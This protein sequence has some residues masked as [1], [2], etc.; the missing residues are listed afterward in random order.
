MIQLEPFC[1]CSN[2]VPGHSLTHALDLAQICGFHHIELASI[3]GISE[4]IQIDRISPGYAAQILSALE[5]RGLTCHAVSAHCDMTNP[6]QFDR[7][8]KKIPF[9]AA[10][11]AKLI[12]TRCGPQ[13]RYSI[14]LDNVNKAADLAD[15][16]GISLHL[17]SYGDIVNT[18]NDSTSVFADINR[19]NVK[20]TYDAGNIFRYAHGKV[21][22][23]SDLTD[24]CMIPAYLH[25][26]DTSLRD[27]WIYNDAIGY[28]QLHIPAILSALEVH[29]P[30]IGC[31]LEIPLSFRVRNDDLVFDFSVPEDTVIIDHVEKSVSFLQGYAEFIL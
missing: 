2:N 11:G 6:E 25:M 24:A 9:A 19:N 31:S 8:L 21:S 13:Y 22:I 15:S 18:A 14:F 3:E 10:I 17:E 20:F 30:K 29:A 5:R 23:E 7:L 16:C 1:F 26:K 4:Q 12:N 27:G 28:G